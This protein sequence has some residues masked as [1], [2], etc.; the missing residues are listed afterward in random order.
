MKQV[1]RIIKESRKVIFFFLIQS[2]KNHF[3]FTAPAL[4]VA[5][6]PVGETDCAQIME[7][8][9]EGQGK[10]LQSRV[11]THACVWQGLPT[12][13]LCGISRD[14]SLSGFQIRTQVIC[15]EGRQFNPVSE[16]FD[17]GESS[18]RLRGS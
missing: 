13:E 1:F 17:E 8:N 15:G 5:Y 2:D 7:G 11:R 18:E 16:V 4:E 9:E 3:H 10:F 6:N 12:A 14:P